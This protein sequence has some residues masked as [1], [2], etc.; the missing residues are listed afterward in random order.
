M[1]TE[2]RG[3]RS[4]VSIPTSDFRLPTSGGEAP[5]FPPV[6]IVETLAWL[7]WRHG[8]NPNFTASHDA[9]REAAMPFRSPDLSGHETARRELLQEGSAR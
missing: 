9:Q 4:E 3:Q 2:V 6:G 5:S 8:I 7:S 1:K